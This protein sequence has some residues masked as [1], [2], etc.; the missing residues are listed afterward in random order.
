MIDILLADNTLQSSAGYGN[1]IVR[2]LY[3]GYKV[4]SAEMT[5]ANSTL[6]YG[7]SNNRIRRVTATNLEDGDII[8]TYSSFLQEY[9]AVIYFNN[10]IYGLNPNG[11]F[12][13]LNLP[14]LSTG[15]SGTLQDYL[16]TLTAYNAFLVFRPALIG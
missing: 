3:G 15:S 14:S 9:R 4:G 2:T 13:K 16:D 1:A 6:N 7:S 11:T 8:L 5:S 12:G 10:R